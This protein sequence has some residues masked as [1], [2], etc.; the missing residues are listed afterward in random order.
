MATDTEKQ[1][2]AVRLVVEGFGVRP[3]LAGVLGQMERGSACFVLGDFSAKR[4][5]TVSYFGPAPVETFAFS[6]DDQGDPFERLDERLGQYRLT[7]PGELPVG[8]VGG[9]VGFLSYDLGRYVERLPDQVVHDNDFP[10]LRFGF[11]DHLVAWDHVNHKGFLLVFDYPGQRSSVQD[12]L[13]G[14]RQLLALAADNRACEAENISVGARDLLQKMDRNIGEDDYLAKVLQAKEYIKAGEIY[15]V[16][17]S[18]RFSCGYGKSPGELYGVLT[19]QNPAAYSAL[20]QWNDQAIVSVSP[21]LF[22]QKR[23]RSLLTRPIKGTM[24]RGKNAQEDQRRREALYHCEKERA[25]LNMIIDLERNDLGR[26]CEIGSVQ[27]LEERV[28]EAHPT[29]FHA[30]AT[31]GGEVRGDVSTAGILRATFPGGSI[32]GAPKIRAMEIIDELEPTARSVYTGSIG[33]FGVNGDFD[34][35]IAIRTIL[36]DQGSACFQAGGAIVDDSTAQGEYQE[37]LTKAAALARALGQSGSGHPQQMTG[38]V[39]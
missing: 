32:T 35:N 33:W 8:F 30:V 37:T 20:L 34:L 27:V 21:E 18:Q 22:L 28:I 6:R 29:L 26:I 13:S 9:W 4:C 19:G 2:T 10:L 38:E 3:A 14:L 5:G 36:L 12:R 1:S 17:L 16:N 15:E 39:L 11:Y 24:A 23:G 31:I 7:N 25:E